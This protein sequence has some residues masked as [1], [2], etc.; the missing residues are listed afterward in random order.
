MGIEEVIAILC[1][2]D[3]PNGLQELMNS[4]LHNG[5]SVSKCGTLAI[6]GDVITALYC[7]QLN[8]VDK[9]LLFMNFE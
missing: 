6:V 3:N 8:I 2:I 9:D 4:N 1:A 5:H 7:K